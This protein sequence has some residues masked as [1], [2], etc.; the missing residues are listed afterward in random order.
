VT[1]TAERPAVDPRIW[2][3]RVAVTRARGRKR[4]RIVLAALALCALLAGGFAA[5]HSSLFGAEHLSVTGEIHTPADEIL[6]VSGLLTHPPLVDIDTASSAEKIEALPWI[7]TA[8][9]FVHWP[10]S[11][12]VSVTERTPVAAVRVPGTAA[13][14]QMWALVDATGR[15]LAYQ[16]VRPRGL[17]A[18]DVFAAPG[19]PGTKLSATD[20]PG[21]DVAGSLPALLDRRVV[22]IDVSPEGGVT[23]G[24]SGDMSAVIGA[25]VDLQ[26]K[27]VALASVLAGAPLA[28]A[29]VINVTVPKEPTVG[30]PT[31]LAGHRG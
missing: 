12:S 17:L 23:L 2:T 1:A 8:R 7:R 31:R 13:A 25:P 20:Q 26:A 11:V 4:L 18:M 14:T 22:S 6:S 10:D 19:A 3:R 27:Y 15:I 21:V 16:S 30:P 24:I 5:V 29:D 28:S 9:V